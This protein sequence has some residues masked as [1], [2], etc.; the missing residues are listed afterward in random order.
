MRK[1][2]NMSV[3]DKRLYYEQYQ[4]EYRKKH[5]HA[6][7]GNSK[8]K[9]YLF[10]EIIPPQEYIKFN[11]IDEDTLRIKTKRCQ[12]HRCNKILTMTEKLYGNNCAKHSIGQTP[13]I[14]NLNKLFK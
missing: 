7:R 8:L 11:P 10:I 5:G 4:K 3:K 14:D 13:N 2:L 9:N 6:E 12:W 1:S